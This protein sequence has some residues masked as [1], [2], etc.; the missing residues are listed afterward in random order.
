MSSQSDIFAHKSRLPFFVSIDRTPT[1]DLVKIWKA[2]TVTKAVEGSILTFKVAE[3]VF[4]EEME[5]DLMVVVGAGEVAGEAME[6]VA[7]EWNNWVF[8]K[9]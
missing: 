2:E 9:Q 8:D 6:G 4:R 5:A 3:V 1:S 7:T